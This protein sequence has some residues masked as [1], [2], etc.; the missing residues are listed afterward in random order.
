MASSRITVR[1][2]PA[3][4]RPWP[5]G[6]SIRPL[7]PKTLTSTVT[8]FGP[9]LARTRCSRRPGAAPP[10]MSHDD[11][12]PGI[13]ADVTK[14]R[15][16]P[17]VVKDH[18]VATVPGAIAPGTVATQWSLTTKGTSRG[19]VTS[20]CIPGAGSSWL[21]AGGA[22]PGRLEHLVLANPGPNPVTVDVSV[23]GAKGRIESPN[24]QALAVGRLDPTFGTEDTDID[25]YRV[26][27]GV[28]KDQVFQTAR[29]GASGDE[30]RRSGPRYTGRCDQAPTGALCR[31]GPLCGNG[32]RGHRPGNRCHTMVLDDKGHQ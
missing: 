6:D 1:P 15:L 9:G 12:A 32:S 3:T 10:A 2:Y 11:P 24:D 13:Q 18:C 19:L 30:P 29:R 17:F 16:V 7:A 21:I 14:P 23:F 26:R 20:A 4:T 22:A 28:G 8:G 25:G 27:P 5:L 31:Q